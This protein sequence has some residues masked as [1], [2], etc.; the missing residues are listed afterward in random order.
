MVFPGVSFGDLFSRIQPTDDVTI[1]DYYGPTF[2]AKAIG[3]AGSEGNK[4][5]AGAVHVVYKKDHQC[6]STPVGFAMLPSPTGEIHGALDQIAAPMATKNRL[7]S[8]VMENAHESIYAPWEERGITNWREDPGP[9]TIYHH[10]P[11]LDGDTFKRRI[12][13]A[14]V[15]GELFG[16]L[17]FLETEQRGQLGYPDS[18]Q[19]VVSTSQASASALQATQG[20]LTSIVRERQRLLS[21][22]Q[23]HLAKVGGDLDRAFLDFDKPLP[24]V[25]GKTATYTPSKVIGETGLV[26]TVEYGAGAGLDVV[27]TDQRLINFK[28]IGTLSSETVLEQTDFIPDARGELAKVENEEIGRILLEKWLSTPTVTPELIGAT[29]ALKK[30]KGISLAEAW[31][32]VQ[33]A[34]MEAQAQM[35]EQGMESQ[36][37]EAVGGAPAPPVEEAPA[38]EAPQPTPEFASTPI[39]LVI[40]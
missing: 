20:Q 14:P 17:Q 19:G 35:Q 21:N 7:V 1:M 29:L 37:G 31:A 23:E 8:L 3:R 28:T 33:T 2:I 13:P 24:N 32:E 25:V 15:N 30:A 16:L 39:H 4:M 40:S 9:N 18:R 27:N 11:S 5:D 10:N 38:A 22:V 6:E 34:A 12:A 26:V 36:L